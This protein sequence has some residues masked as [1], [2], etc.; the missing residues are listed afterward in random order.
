MKSKKDDKLKRSIL[1]FQDLKDLQLLGYEKNTILTIKS[2]EIKK[3]KL[4]DI[5]ELME[6]FFY[7]DTEHNFSLFSKEQSLEEYKKLIEKL[8]KYIKNLT[9]KNKICSLIEE[10]LKDKKKYRTIYLSDIKLKLEEI[11]IENKET[12]IFSKDNEKKKEMILF[13]EKYELVDKILKNSILYKKEDFISFKTKL[14]QDT[15]YKENILLTHLYD[16]EDGILIQYLKLFFFISR[17]IEFI[18]EEM[19]FEIFKIRNSLENNFLKEIEGE[20][21]SKNLLF[22]SFKVKILLIIF[23]EKVYYFYLKNNKSKRIEEIIKKI[24]SQKNIS[25]EVVSKYIIEKYLE[26][27]NEQ[28]KIFKNFLRYEKKKINVNF[29]DCLFDK[30]EKSTRKEFIKKGNDWEL[31]KESYSRDEILTEKDEKFK[32]FCFS[33]IFRISLYYELK[34]I[35][36]LEKI[37]NELKKE[38]D[39]NKK[40]IYSQIKMS[41]N[42][43]T[44][45]FNGTRNLG[46]KSKKKIINYLLEKNNPLFT[47]LLEEFLKNLN[48]L[49]LYNSDFISININRKEGEEIYPHLVLDDKKISF[50]VNSDI[51]GKTVVEIEISN[52]HCSNV[53]KESTYYAV[54]IKENISILGFSENED[55]R[56]L[57]FLKKSENEEKYYFVSSYDEFY[58]VNDIK[59][60]FN[61]EKIKF[62]GLPNQEIIEHPLSHF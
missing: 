54:K 34:L 47:T 25:I 30:K 29:F 23:F 6:I 62:L 24:S 40:D 13:E 20:E 59:N 39:N 41:K 16:I 1:N 50:K 8:K 15:F 33:N 32:R 53:L 37:N 7:I 14:S 9:L 56:I 5:N 26:K 60:I 31:K 21:S 44:S 45:I 19:I 48:M 28:K 51:L 22:F 27:I 17:P 4:E 55:T 46:E 49:K 57:K 11:L 43:C 12:I 2:Q 58:I 35:E 18:T 42:H 36:V 38:N 10:L 61:I 52:I 3:Y